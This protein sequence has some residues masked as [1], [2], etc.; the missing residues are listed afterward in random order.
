MLL[1]RCPLAGCCRLCSPVNSSP[2]FIIPIKSS[3]TIM[4]A[5]TF[6]SYL[7]VKL[8]IIGAIKRLAAHPSPPSCYARASVSQTLQKNH[9]GEAPYFISPNTSLITQV[10]GAAKA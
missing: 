10:A 7:A 8:D 3:Y 4:D 9:E 6:R 1:N 5:D 2:S